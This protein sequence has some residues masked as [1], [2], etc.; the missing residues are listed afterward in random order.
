MVF[1]KVRYSKRRF[2]LTCLISVQK[3]NIHREENM[4]Q[5]LARRRYAIYTRIEDESTIDTRFSHDH[6]FET[7]AAAH[8]TVSAL[9]ESGLD[10]VKEARVGIGLRNI[11]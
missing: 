6:L 3:R 2:V 7:E 5:W 8:N 4:M 1:I 10:A 11:P 9:A